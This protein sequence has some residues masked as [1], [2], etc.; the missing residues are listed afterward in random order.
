[1]SYR[2][3]TVFLSC[4]LLTF[5]GAC[6]EGTSNQQTLE[7]VLQS[8]EQLLENREA[9]FLL[10]SYSYGL[11]LEQYTE[12]AAKKAATPTVKSFAESSLTYYR[13]LKQELA[14]LAAARQLT[15]PEQP[16]QDVQDYTQELAELP[17]ADF[18]KR[19]LQVLSDVQ[20]KIIARYETAAEGEL[21]THLTDWSL[22]T[23]PQ[24]RAHA[25]AVTEL[26]KQLE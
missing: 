16:G 10:D 15:L 13:K 2:W 1:M 5:S 9:S 11:I 14:G 6:K 22:Q 24:L 18:E 26:L 12:L 25:Q 7:P 17:A 20:T 21:D 4:A 19:Y 8:N 23:L 3:Q